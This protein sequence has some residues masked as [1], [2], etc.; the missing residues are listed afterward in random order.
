MAG[1]RMTPQTF[2]PLPAGGAPSARGRGAEGSG[3][4]GVNGS[5]TPPLVR[6][7]WS[8]QDAMHVFA[9]IRQ[10][11]P[12]DPTRTFLFGYSAGGQGAHYIG[13]K[14]VEDW[15]AVAIGGSNAMPADSYPYARLA[16]T[17]MMIF[18]GSEDTPNVTPSRTMAQA[19][20]QHGIDA[21]LKEYTG[22]NHDSAPSAATA[23]IFAF[24]DAHPRR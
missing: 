20:Q 4:G 6:S 21:V 23:D 8:E 17:P 9:L 18:V 16:N 7:E 3:F 19:L 10:E 22:A 11:Y 15:A 1:A 2:G 12:I 14:Y 24:F 5:V 13:P